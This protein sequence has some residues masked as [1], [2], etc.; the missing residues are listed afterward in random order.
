MK[1]FFG[2][3]VF[4]FGVYFLVSSETNA[5]EQKPRV[6]PKAGVS[7]TVG[8]TN[9]SVTYSRPGVKGRTIWGELVSYDKIWRA[10]AD[11]ATAISFSADVTIEG[12]NLPAGKYS[13]FTIPGKDKWTIIFNKVAEQWGSYNYDQT[14]DALRVEVN[15]YEGSF[16][17]WLRFSFEDLTKESATLILEW[18][19]LKV[20]VKIGTKL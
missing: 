3:F 11:E 1:T 13:F 14:Q 9:I 12:Q 16:V 15:P 8:I 6:S 2:L 20:P 19:K 5:Q 18:E 7:Q 17:E 10:G 4:L